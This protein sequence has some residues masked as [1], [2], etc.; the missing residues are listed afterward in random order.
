MTTLVNLHGTAR[1]VPH[2]DSQFWGSFISWLGSTAGMS[3]DFTAGTLT[4][5][6]A[7]GRQVARA[8]DWL[9]RTMDKALH[10]ARAS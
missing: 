1:Q 8:G 6:T 10:L 5:D 3:A 4:L 7:E 9:I 2:P